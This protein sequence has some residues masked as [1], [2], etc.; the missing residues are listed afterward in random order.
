MATRI[1]TPPLQDCRDCGRPVRT[2]RNGPLCRRCLSLLPALGQLTLADADPA[3]ELVAGPKP[4]PPP[5]PRDPK[6]RRRANADNRE[7]CRECGAPQ[8]GQHAAGC[9]EEFGF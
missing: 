1:G 7:R 8:P 5:K 4:A 6:K 2:W 3:W 9:S